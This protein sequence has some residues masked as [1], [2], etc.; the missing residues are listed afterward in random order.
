[1]KAHVGVHSMTQL[2]H[3]I[4]ASAANILDTIALPPLL[5]GKQTRV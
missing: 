2:I 3:P 4:L 5:L 1:M